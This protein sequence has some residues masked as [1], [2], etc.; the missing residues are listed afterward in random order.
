MLNEFLEI[1]D[2]LGWD[3]SVLFIKKAANELLI[4]CDDYFNGYKHAIDND[5]DG[6]LCFKIRE[7]AIQNI[8]KYLK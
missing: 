3:E 7:K 6:G 4:F 2:E 1:N 8:I 5:I